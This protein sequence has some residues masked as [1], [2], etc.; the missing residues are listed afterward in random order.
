MEKVNLYLGDVRDQIQKVADHSVDLIYW[1][2]DTTST[3]LSTESFVMIE[4]LW[5]EINRVAKPNCRLIVQAK[6]PVVTEFMIKL[7]DYYDTTWYYINP[8]IGSSTNIGMVAKPLERVEE[9]MVFTLNR[10]GRKPVFNIL[11]S[12]RSLNAPKQFAMQS[13]ENYLE[14][15]PD[16]FMKEKGLMASRPVPALEYLIKIYS[17]SDGHVLDLFM[18]TGSMG[19]AALN[20]KRFYSGIDINMDKFSMAV[21]RITAHLHSPSYRKRISSK[22]GKT[23]TS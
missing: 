9:L 3:K 20:T 10:N 19:L 14:L 11:N 6:Q 21:D 7:E 15:E 13:P 23:I 4:E 18:G 8:P 2:P 22:Y 1:D 12:Y 5:D 17:N 16:A